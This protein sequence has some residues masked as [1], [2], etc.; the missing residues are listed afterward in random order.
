VGHIKLVKEWDR[1]LVTIRNI[2]GFEDFLRPKMCAD[3]MRGL[4]DEGAIVIINIDND[5]CDALALMAGADEPMHILLPQFSYKEA[6]R[7]AKGFAWS[8]TSSQSYIT[9]RYT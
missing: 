6:E 7:L 2:S 1:L 9:D 3:I 4:P 5:R 8:P